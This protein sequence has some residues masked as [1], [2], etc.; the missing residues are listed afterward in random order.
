MPGDHLNRN[1]KFEIL[2]R[3]C[4]VFPADGSETR[5]VHMLAQTVAVEDITSLGSHSRYFDMISTFGASYRTT[6]VMAHQSALDGLQITY[7]FFY[8][9]SHNLPININIA[10]IIGETPSDLDKKKRLFW[11]GDVVVAMKVQ[12][13]G[14]QLNFHVES[15]DA[16]LFELR[17]LEEFLREFYQEGV[18]ECVLRDNEHRCE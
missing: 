6:R 4:I 15:L 17:P 2:V 14:E 11:R 3:K 18:H 12:P 8:N 16:D 1:D 13:K 9:L 10:N 7:L 5:L